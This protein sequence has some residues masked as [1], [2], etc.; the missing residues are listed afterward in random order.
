MPTNQSVPA[1]VSRAGLD[2]NYSTWNAGTE[3]TLSN[4]PWNADYR[5]LVRFDTQAKL[6]AYINGNYNVKVQHASLVKFDYTVRINVPFNAVQQFNYLRAH[7]PTSPNDSARTFYYFVKDVNYIAPDTTEVVLQVDVWQTFGRSVT[8]GR[9]FIERGHIGIA[10]ENAYR[11]YGRDYLTVPEGLDVGSE[12]QITGMREYCIAMPKTTAVVDPNGNELDYAFDIVMVSTVSF[13]GDPGTVDDPKLN[14]ASGTLFEGLPNGADIYWMPDTDAFTNLMLNYQFRPWITQG[15]V[16]VMAVPQLDKDW[17]RANSTSIK[18]VGGGELRKFNRAGSVDKSFEMYKDFRNQIGMSSTRYEKLTKFKTYP[19]TIIELTTYSGNPL[20]LKPECIASDS[21]WVTQK[22][23]IVPPN[24]RVAFIPHDYNASRQGL[25]LK[26]GEYLNMQTGIMDMPTFSV[27]NNS[28][29]SYMAANRNAI[30]YQHSSADWSQQKALRGN[31]VS[32]QNAYTSLGNT[33]EQTAIANRAARQNAELSNDIA[34]ARAMQ[35]AG[36]ALLSGTPM[37]MVGGGFNTAMDYM[38]NTSATDRSTSIATGARTNSSAATINAGGR[39]ADSNKAYADYAARGDYQ[40]AIAGINAKVQDAKL[41][42]PTTS[43]QIGGDAFN[44]AT[45]GWWLTAKIKQIQPD[46]MAMIGEYWLRYG[47]A[48]QRFAFPPSDL[49]C[50]SHFTYWKMKETYLFG[51]M[52]EPFKQAIR[53]I[54]ENGVT[55]WSA[56]E[57]VGQIDPVINTP[58]NGISYE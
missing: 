21:L 32:Q 53:G 20:I 8:F 27:V 41:M 33:G 35:G 29:M 24:P 15:I 28:Y 11:N 5:D 40:N 56:P 55:V 46:A 34:G 50:M 54:F 30:A 6:D 14:T 31:E 51:N 1:S 9:C 57:Y 13:E 42:Q 58:M 52:P 39:I 37:G 44:L 3:I 19:Y 48:V 4:V 10:N 16:S 22:T 12:Y 25:P 45:G 18:H 49:K 23:H 26:N 36:N 2:F 47:Y 17:V 43:G 7:N 38:V